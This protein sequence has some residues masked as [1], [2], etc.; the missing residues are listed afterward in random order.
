[1]SSKKSRKI[2]FASLTLHSAVSVAA[3]I[4]ILSNSVRASSIGLRWDFSGGPLVA[5]AGE[6]DLS[7]RWSINLD[8][9]GFPAIIIRGE[10]DLRYYTGRSWPS[11]WQ[12]GQGRYWFFRGQGEGHH[13]NE[14]HLRSGIS[15]ELN[16]SWIWFMDI[17]L[18]WAPLQINPWIRQQFPEAIPIVPLA[19]AGIMW[20]F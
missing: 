2:E 3:T 10:V 17:G 16:G 6:L 20:R 4:L 18:L 19:G 11:Y 13:V 12:V 7:D 1:V 8:C 15:R 14:F 9:G 5:L